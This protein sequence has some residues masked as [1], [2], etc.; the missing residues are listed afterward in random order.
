[1]IGIEMGLDGGNS[2][3]N[4]TSG[5]VQSLQL[6]QSTGNSTIHAIQTNGISSSELRVLL[7]EIIST[8]ETE[9]NDPESMED[10]R[11]SI[12]IVRAQMESGE[13]KRGAL[14]GALSVLHGV[15]GGVQFMAALVQI[16]E[17]INT[18]GCNYDWTI[19]YCRTLFG[20]IED[21]IA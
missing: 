4:N 21:V 15:N 19:E 9:I 14:T 8:A 5:S 12:E 2:V 20:N 1:M 7:D 10:V 13:P 3:T 11:D 18:S 17:F 6:N 16:I